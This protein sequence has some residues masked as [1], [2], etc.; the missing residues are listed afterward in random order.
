MKKLGFLIEKALLNAA[1]CWIV[2]EK[3]VTCTLLRTCVSDK[4]E[5]EVDAN[6]P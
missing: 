2:K 1:F 6:A 5:A 3:R 4:I